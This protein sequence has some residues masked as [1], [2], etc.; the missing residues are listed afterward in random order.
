MPATTETK[1]IAALVFRASDAPE[2]PEQLVSEAR[3]RIHA[4]YAG[5]PVHAVQGVRLIDALR[6]ALATSEASPGGE[7]DSIAVFY[8]WYPLLDGA[9]SAEAAQDHAQYL[10]HFT[11]GENIPRGLI[12]DFASREFITS[13]PEDLPDD[14]RGFVFKKIDRYDVELFYR[15]PDL[16]QYRLDVSCSSPRSQRLAMDILQRA[17]QMN[18]AG[19]AEFLRREPEILRPY[20]TYFEIEACAAAEVRPIYLPQPETRRDAVLD[21]A[22]IH[23]LRDDIQS[24]GM[25][26]DVTVAFAGPGDVFLHPR[27]PD[28]IEAFTQ[29]DAVQRVFVETY[30]VFHDTDPAALVARLA[31]IEPSHKLTLIVRLSTLRRDRYNELYGGDR[32]TEVQAFLTALQDALSGGPARFTACVEMLRL[33]ATDDEVTTFMDRFE[34]EGSR[35][36]PLLGK[37]NSYAGRLPE[38]R[39]ADLTP[40]GRDFCWH[41]ARDLYVTAEGRVPLCKQD[42]FAERETAVDL[43]EH[44]VAGILARTAGYHAASTRGEHERIPMPCLQCDEWYTFNG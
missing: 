12:P 5:V 21:D 1:I 34:A 32:L 22:L 6:S 25:P 44:D 35:L 10:A 8:D 2:P 33:K 15:T 16:R 20:P 30:G 17:P 43:R 29:L 27:W 31:T 37:Y 24:N 36:Q 26:G 4:L 13:L 38:R 41:L 9:L 14:L 23:K 40:L 28:I 39:A 19:L 3:R 7:Q 11:Y 18:F 42:V